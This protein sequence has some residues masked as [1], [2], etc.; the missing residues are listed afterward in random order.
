MG[1]NI[2]G[3]LRAFYER[4]RNREIFHARA[5]ASNKRKETHASAK[6]IYFIYSFQVPVR[7]YVL[8]LFEVMLIIALP[9]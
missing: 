9:L 8:N 1:R 6:K 3:C 7:G 2:Q 5:V 4:W